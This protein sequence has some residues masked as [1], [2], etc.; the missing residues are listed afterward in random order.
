[1]VEIVDFGEFIYH[2]LTMFAILWLFLSAGYNFCTVLRE[3]TIEIP[4][5]T[6]TD[7]Q[8][9]ATLRQV[10]GGASVADACSK[11]GV[12]EHTFYRRKG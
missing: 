6:I 10:E 2:D 4:K 7:E 9:V 8:I 11:V 1:M 5:K 12:T 3:K